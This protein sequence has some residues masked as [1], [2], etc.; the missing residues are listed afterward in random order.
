[1]HA[2]L[3]QTS[4]PWQIDP[5]AAGLTDP[6]PIAQGATAAGL[7][8]KAIRAAAIGGVAHGVDTRPHTEEQARS[9]LGRARPLETLLPN[10]ACRVARSALGGIVAQVG[11]A[12]VGRVRVTVGS[13]DVALEHIRSE[14]GIFD[15]A[16]VV[17]LQVRSDLRRLRGVGRLGGVLRGVAIGVDGVHLD[18]A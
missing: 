1:M 7:S 18:I 8:I 11:L 2:P 13:I 14:I 10:S 16:I 9:A 12:A 5:F 6:S 3:V 17:N 4:V 15:A